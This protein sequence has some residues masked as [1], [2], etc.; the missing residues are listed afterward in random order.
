[1]E[2]VLKVRNKQ[3]LEGKVILVNEYLGADVDGFISEV[4]E[5]YP[6]H[7]LI[8]YHKL[9]SE[10]KTAD[11]I[12]FL[13]KTPKEFS[14]AYKPRSALI[15]DGWSHRNNILAE[16]EIHIMDINNTRVSTIKY[17]DQT[18][19][20]LNRSVT[21]PYYRDVYRSYALIS[22]RPLAIATHHTHSLTISMRSISIEMCLLYSYR[23]PSKYTL[24]VQQA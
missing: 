7:M 23:Y 4:L 5:E 18:V 8:S 1:M 24:F 20:I 14:E 22:L 2:Y 13:D 15:I 11:V 12:S 19:F 21:K 10:Y 6:S 16:D 9:S 3:E 17:A